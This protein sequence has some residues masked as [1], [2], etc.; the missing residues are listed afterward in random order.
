VHLRFRYG[1]SH[2]LRPQLA[3][4]RWL[5]PR[6]TAAFLLD[7]SP[8]TAMRRKPHHWT[9]AEFELQRELY[10][11]ELSNHRAVRLDAECP[12]EEICAQLAAQTW[13]RMG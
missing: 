6:P 5:S 1:E 4:L 9:A 10:R 13:R 12:P 7:I 11:E 8:A 3:L 2:S